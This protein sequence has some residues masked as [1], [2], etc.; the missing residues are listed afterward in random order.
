MSSISLGRR[1]V[2]PAL[3]IVL[4]ASLLAFVG[5]EPASAADGDLDP[6]FSGDGRVVSDFG[7]DES[8]E[9]VAVQPDGRIVVAG[10]GCGGA[11]LVARYDAGGNL[12]PTFDG[13]GWVCVDAGP[14]TD[15]GVDV[16]VLPDGRLVV[17]GT[18]GGD[19]VLVRLTAAGGV[20]PTFGAGGRATFDF[21]G[22]DELRDVALAPDGRIVMVGETPTVGCV[23]LPGPTPGQ[24][25]GVAVARALPDGSPD[26]SFG[27]D[28]TVVLA[29]DNLVQRGL[30]VAVHPD[31]RVVVGGRTASCT[32]VA[33]DFLLV[34]LTAGGEP[35]PTFDAG[36]P[37]S[38]TGPTSVADLVV[39]PDGKIV[40][41]I[42]TFVGPATGPPRD[43]AFTVARFN[44]DGTPDTSFDGDGVAA[45]LF[46]EGVNATPTSVV[47]Q[48]GKITVGG[49]TDGNFAIARF[50]ADGTPDTSFGPGG[51][52]VTD[53][54]GTDVLNALAVQPDGKLVA[55]S[56]TGTDVAVAR[57]GTVTSPTTS[58]STSSTSTPSTTST[59]VASP[60]GALCPLLAPIRSV[61]A[62]SPWLS[63][64]VS[65]LDGL[66]A[67]FGC[68]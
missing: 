54:G 4:V 23:G 60:F 63:P 61:F 42:D 34:R 1:R 52:V 56:Q 62:A 46:G 24:S 48:A 17:A 22:V 38:L 14:G 53:F 2:A 20:D 39:Q 50:N 68:A 21:G 64:F 27:G 49:S 10:T 25:V 55:A 43:D 59:T 11:F 26:P 30:A 65:I 29:S 28:G 16:L 31:G 32:R 7:S 5:A 12:D 57:Y 19:F 35:D 45:A 13:D 67:G 36:H 58:T 18:S 6:S 51:M 3:T 41:A 47:L 33:I 40:A 66:R 8:A 37:A 15:R 9:G 44:P